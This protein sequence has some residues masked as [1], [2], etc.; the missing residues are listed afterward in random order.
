VSNAVTDP[1][2]GPIEDYALLSDLRTAALVGLDGSI[3]W[4]CLPSFDSGSCFGRLLGNENHGRWK[5]APAG[6]VRQ[7]RR[8]YRENTMVLETEFQTDSG[9]VRLIDT[10]CPQADR[11]DPH[12]QPRVIRV[13]EGVSGEVE[14]TLRWVVRFAYGDAVP[15]V[16]RYRRHGE[17]YLLALAGPRAVTLRGDLLPHAV[18]HQ[19]AHEE[20]FT[21]GAGERFSWVMEYLPDPDEQPPPVDTED[22]IRKCEA[23]WRKWSGQIEYDGPHSEIV[24]R[25]LATLKGL[26]Y[27][28]TGS[29]VAAPT[30]SLPET[31]GGERNWDYRYCW[32][33]D[34]T[35]TLLAFDNFGLS[36]EAEAWRTWLLRAVAGDPANL[37]IMYGLRGERHLI[38]WECDWLPGYQG[39]KPVRVGNAAYKQLQLDVYGEVM[40]A[41]HLARERGLP[42]TQDSWSLQRGLLRHLEKIWQEPDN[43]LWEVRGPGRHF[44]HG[45]VMVWVAF[46]RAVRA[47]EEDGLPGPVHRWRELRDTLHAEV[48]ENGFNEKIGAFTQYYGSTELDA[49]TLLIPA[50]GFLPGTDERVRATIDAIG[51]ELKHGDLIDRYSTPHDGQSDVDGLHGHEGAFLMCSFWYVDALAL[52]GRQAEAEAMF[53]RLLGLCNDV[54]LLPEEY[55]AETKRFLGNFPQAFSHLALVNSANVLYRSKHDRHHRSRRVFAETE[56]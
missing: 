3:D 26:G 13:V 8:W 17:E 4:L 32:L 49:A 2:P 50:V 29:I 28:P 27:A 35:L 14:M 33:R 45:R 44:T 56:E 15:W 37:Q 12:D 52:S 48:L 53:E 5:I 54:G 55:E 23:F 20:T 24:L 38:E 19:R 41:L 21:V 42:E 39:A 47:V 16:R 30:T 22:D 31:P 34:A 43:G 40:D 10:M 46:D 36:A 25:S 6:E 7:T 1:G 51:R 18:P 11:H 9:V